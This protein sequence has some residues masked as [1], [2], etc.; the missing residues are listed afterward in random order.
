MYNWS[1]AD[2]TTQAIL[3]A[4]IPTLAVLIGILVNNSRLSDLRSDM[5]RRFDTMNRRF[6]DMGR[7]FDDRFDEVNR[8]IEDTRDLLRAEFLRVEQVLDARVKHLEENR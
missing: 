1:M 2:A 5:D 8:R 7:R 3:A 4:T 6:D